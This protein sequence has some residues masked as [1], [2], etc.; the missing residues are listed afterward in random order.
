MMW[1]HS[2]NTI[3]MASDMASSNGS[4]DSDTDTSSSS[5]EGC[6]EVDTNSIKP[7]SFE[8]HYDASEIEI[9]QM[10]TDEVED[11]AID[12]VHRRDHRDWYNFNF[13]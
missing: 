2:Q 11:D 12:G 4:S 13:T 5:N 3:N 8:P 10:S 6:F 1:R 9:E 7:Y